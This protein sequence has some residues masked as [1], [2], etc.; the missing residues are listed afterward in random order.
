MLNREQQLLVRAAALNVGT[1]P[2]HGE[3]LPQMKV[4]QAKVR[5][6]K[7]EP[8]GFYFNRRVPKAGEMLTM[9]LDEARGLAQRGLVEL[10]V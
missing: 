3:R 7:T 4:R 1:L 2:S 9:D 8:H 5:V 10:L 6:L